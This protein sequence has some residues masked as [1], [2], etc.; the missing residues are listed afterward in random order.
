MTK[1]NN[2]NSNKLG[3][4]QTATSSRLFNPD[5][6]IYT[7]IIYEFKLRKPL[8]TSGRIDYGLL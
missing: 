7:I 2:Q 3:Y 5:Y 4:Y 6:L 8:R 1:I